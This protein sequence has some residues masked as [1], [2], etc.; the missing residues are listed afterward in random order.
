[1]SPADSD[2]EFEFA[3]VIEGVADLTPPVTDALFDAGCDDATFSIQYGRL[4]AEFSRS[5]TC[6]KDAILTA[7]RDIRRAKVGAVILRVDESDLVTQ[8]EIGRRIGRHRQ[9]VH[10]Y[11]TGKRGPGNFPAPVCHL[12]EGTPLWA[13]CDVS[14]WLA[15]NNIIRPEEGLNAEVVATVNASLES[16]IHHVRN[17]KLAREIEE[18][19]AT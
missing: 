4:Y 17:P 10:Q 8:A 7:I 6:L 16:A 5:A 2:R 12:G 3:L 9:M 15:Q 14:Y 13:W 1:M 18:A 19:L 11:I